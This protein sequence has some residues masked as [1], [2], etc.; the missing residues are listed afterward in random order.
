MNH[1]P[2]LASPPPTVAKVPLE[3]L[4]LIIEAIP[5]QSR[6]DVSHLA[7]C[8][9]V[10]RTIR[11]WVVPLLYRTVSLNSLGAIFAFAHNAADGALLHVRFLAVEPDDWSG[12]GIAS[13]ACAL[14]VA[15]FKRLGHTLAGLEW[16]RWVHI[17]DVLVTA[18]PQMMSF[19]Y[20]PRVVLSSL[21]GQ[22]IKRLS[23][24]Y[25][26]KQWVDILRTFPNAT[27]LRFG[28]RDRH[29]QCD[30]TPDPQLLE[31]LLDRDVLRLER[32][33]VSV[34]DDEVDATCEALAVLRDERVTV[35]SEPREAELGAFERHARG[36]DNLWEGRQAWRQGCDSEHSQ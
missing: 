33:V 23:F 13:D 6:R 17:K 35:A 30:C 29:S 18:R 3:L 26:T 12:F 10:C 21:S 34:F 5:I 36:L 7:D 4:R 9:L 25:Q 1:S 16:P 19:H 27:H 11:D 22:C 28:Y 2:A 14:L 32:L 31:L 15:R 8:A 20:G 24:A